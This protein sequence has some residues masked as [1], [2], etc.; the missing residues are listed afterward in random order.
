M[1]RT[2][3]AT[4]TLF[5]NTS[6]SADRCARRVR[7]PEKGWPVT[8]RNRT[9]LIIGL[10]IVG[11]VALLYGISQT[12]T[13][14]RFEDLEEHSTE[15]GV[16]RAIVALDHE[17][18]SLDNLVADWAAW[19]DTYE[20]VQDGNQEY[21][22]S[23]LV[24]ETFETNRLNVMLAIDADGHVVF[25]KAFDPQDALEAPMPPGLEQHLDADSILIRH[26]SLESSTKGIILLA[27]GPMLIASRPVLTSSGEGPIRGTMVMGR[28]LDSAEIGKLAELSQ[29]SLDVRQS[30]SPD[31]PP[32]FRAALESISPT[33]PIYVHA[34]SS[35]SIAGYTL[36]QDI[37][38]NPGLVMR[39]EMPRPVYELSR[40]VSRN[41]VLV[42][43]IAGLVFIILVLFLLERLVLSRLTRLS[44]NVTSIGKRGDMSARLTVKGN[45]ELSRLGNSINEMLGS[46]EQSHKRTEALHAVART[47]S[48][49]LDM[50]E[51]LNRG[52]GKVVEVMGTDAGSI[53]LLDTSEKTLLLKA[54]KGMSDDAISKVAAIKLDEA[55][56][57][58]VLQW[59]DPSTPLAQ[60]H[61]ETTL[62]VITEALEKERIRSFAAVP[63]SV[64]GELQGILSVS[65]RD[66]REFGPDDIGLLTAIGNEI[67]V[68]IQNAKLLEKTRELSIT[69]ELTGLYNRRHFY[70][71]LEMEVGRTR[72]YGGSFSVVMLDLDGFKQYND[73]FGHATGDIILRSVASTFKSALR[74]S[75]TSFRYGGDEFTFILPA[76][77]AARAV[78][79]VDR[80][81]VQWAETARSQHS[82]DESRLGFSAGIAQ[83]P[84]DAESTDG[85]ITLADAALYRSKRDGGNR[86]TLSSD[87]RQ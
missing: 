65:S 32:D 28:Y 71:T 23:N 21:I 38:G 45:D 57:R 37:Y 12:V 5:E 63:L 59:T 58:R 60:V 3:L 25:A 39:T 69:D 18:S 24:D 78:R 20:F 67:G 47:V 79:I 68:G 19:D 43:L 10:T 82:V 80:I 27:E 49:T 16:Q 44:E 33:T 26:S 13:V 72:R 56:F 85:L 36:V 74:E 62:G 55:E 31:L 50:G 64:R 53:Y 54:Q 9:L 22:E 42:V 11:F 84:G 34:L 30:N 4:T 48:Q 29:L 15:Q 75:D 46:L 76:T 86:S 35:E 40:G 70:E 8:L 7:S 17:L 52:L 77:D 83:F 66:H 1:L 81:R 87:L 73:R 61:S 41:L 2:R 6:R 51:L 14:G